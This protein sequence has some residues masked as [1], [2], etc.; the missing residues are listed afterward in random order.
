MGYS[1]EGCKELD[2]TEYIMQASFSDLESYPLPTLAP[3]AP[4]KELLVF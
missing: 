4:T 2:T 1:P 3:T